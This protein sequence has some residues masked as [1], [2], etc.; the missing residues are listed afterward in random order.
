LLLHG[1]GP[2]DCCTALPRCEGKRKRG[3]IAFRYAIGR[4]R[5]LKIS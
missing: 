4:G 1:N 3:E 5:R 2:P